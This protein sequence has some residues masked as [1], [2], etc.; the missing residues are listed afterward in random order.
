MF[1]NL[2]FIL[3]KSI[4]IYGICSIVYDPF[5][6]MMN[7]LDV[8]FITLSYALAIESVFLLLKCS[9]INFPDWIEVIEDLY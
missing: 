3:F 2:S 5:I 8:D 6:S 9:N 7:S 4:K 1:S